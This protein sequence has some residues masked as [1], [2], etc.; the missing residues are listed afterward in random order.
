M[1]LTA[2]FRQYYTEYG[3]WPDFT[4]DGMFVDAGRNARLMRVLTGHDDINNPHRIS[5]FEGL[6]ATKQEMWSDRLSGGF[7][8][9]TGTFLDPW[10]YP[11]RI[12]LDAD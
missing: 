1:Q 10:G 7:D 9:D 11:F 12:V 5:F 8:P 4:G 6:T 3:K 2:A